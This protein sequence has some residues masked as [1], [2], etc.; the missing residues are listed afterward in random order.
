M[1]LGTGT[2][3]RCN[4]RSVT[5]RDR[6]PDQGVGKARTDL[7]ALGDGCEQGHV[8]LAHKADEVGVD[9]GGRI[10]R[11]G[12]GDHF[13]VLQQGE[14][15]RAR[16]IGRMQQAVSQRGAHADRGIVEEADQ[17]RVE[18]GMLVGGPVCWR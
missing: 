5:D 9:Q 1:R 18:R 11:H 8:R 17:G 14:Q 12:A 2:S 3:S 7:L 10:L 4:S 15:D 16:R 13:A 6:A